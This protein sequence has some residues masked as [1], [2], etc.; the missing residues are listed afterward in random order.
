M[1]YSEFWIQK[2]CITHYRWWCSMC[3]SSSFSHHFT[4]RENHLGSNGLSD[5]GYGKSIGEAVRSMWSWHREMHPNTILLRLMLLIWPQFRTNYT[6]PPFH[7][8]SFITVSKD[9]LGTIIHL[10]FKPSKLGTE[11]HFGM[12]E[13]RCGKSMNWVI[14]PTGYDGSNAKS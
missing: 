3:N 5:S 1:I 8:L 6:N 12:A 10:P 13:F 2:I 7:Q 4:L 14:F 11:V 9:Q